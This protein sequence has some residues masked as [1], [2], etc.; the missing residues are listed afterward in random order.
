MKERLPYDEKS[1]GMEGDIKKHTLFKNCRICI[2][3]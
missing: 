2:E 3:L 1:H